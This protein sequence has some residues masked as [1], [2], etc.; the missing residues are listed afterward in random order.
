MSALSECVD[1]VLSLSHSLFLDFFEYDPRIRK[2]I[3]VKCLLFYGLPSSA[4]C[5]ALVESLSRI[6][7]MIYYARRVLLIIK[8]ND[9]Y[10][11]PEISL[12]VPKID[13]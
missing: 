8:R 11:K 5:C 3:S 1:V 10:N 13:G 9:L 12:Q 4:L 7:F 6:A 2:Q